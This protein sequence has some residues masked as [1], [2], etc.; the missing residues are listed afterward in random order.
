VYLDAVERAM[1]A[2]RAPRTDRLQVLQDLEVQIAD[3]LAQQPQPLTEESIC[4]VIASLEPPSQFAADYATEK[5]SREST[6]AA[7]AGPTGTLA[8]NRWAVAAAISCALIPVGC[9]LLLLA[10]AERLH[11]PVVGALVLLMLVGGVI[12]PIALWK[13]FQQLRA[14]PK[15]L[16]RDL[17]LPTLAIYCT[18]VPALL[19]IL[20]C[21]ATDGYLLI[22]IGIAAFG[23]LQYVHVR[24]FWQRAADT[25]PSQPT[26]AN[27]THEQHPTSPVSFSTAL[28]MPAV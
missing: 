8:R 22:P 3:M 2:A 6:D 14:E 19:F 9:V 5:E 23:Y 15:L 18:V 1:T 16:G 27:N 12:T 28:S 10:G 20:A 26:P 13:A 24:R 25:L 11:G 4:A 21:V 17:A 7:Q